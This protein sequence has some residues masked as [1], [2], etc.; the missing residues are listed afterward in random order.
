MLKSFFP[1]KHEGFLFSLNSNTKLSDVMTDIKEDIEIKEVS[2]NSYFEIKAIREDSVVESFRQKIM[3]NQ[4]CV[5]IYV[6]DRVV[7]HAACV[8]PGN[9]EGAFSVRKSAYLHFCYVVS[10][11]RGHNLYPMMLQKLMSICMK[12]Y[13]VS[14]FS[15]MTSKDNI[16]SQK[17]LKKVG[18]QFCKE[19]RYIEW[20]RFVWPRIEV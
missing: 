20:W 8:L 19:F 1:V 7:G 5:Y 14:E 9:R 2:I 18:F 11:W 4:L 12:R 16:S 3:E 15:I 6:N 13:N 17:G 10:E